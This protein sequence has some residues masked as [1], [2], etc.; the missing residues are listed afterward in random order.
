MENSFAFTQV[1]K[2]QQAPRPE[3][4][5]QD[6]H[7]QRSTQKTPWFR[8]EQAD[9]MLTYLPLRNVL[10]QGIKATVKNKALPDSAR[11]C[12]PHLVTLSLFLSLCLADLALSRL[13]SHVFSLLLMPFIMRTPLDS[14][15]S[16]PRH[17]NKEWVCVLSHSV[18]SESL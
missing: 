12:T 18:I 17:T 13:V 2:C 7:K 14:A 10:I 16:G 6:P 11:L 8:E 1:T 3:D 4:N 9:V 5:V 15:E